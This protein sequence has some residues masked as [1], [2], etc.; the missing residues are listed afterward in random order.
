M[1]ECKGHLFRFF[2][3]NTHS[4]LTVLIFI[5]IVDGATF[6]ATGN[7][8]RI[9]NHDSEDPSTNYLAEV[10]VYGMPLGLLKAVGSLLV[11]ESIPWGEWWLSTF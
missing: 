6:A 7:I 8:N 11:S 3:L 10:C 1:N 5:V 4:R 9:V 2:T